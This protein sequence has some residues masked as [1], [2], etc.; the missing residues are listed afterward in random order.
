MRI[1][2]KLIEIL[3]IKARGVRAR[4]RHVLC[5]PMYETSACGQYCVLGQGFLSIDTEILDLER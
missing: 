4:M 3:A 5:R 1:N 2:R